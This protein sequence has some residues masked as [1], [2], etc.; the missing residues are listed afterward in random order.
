MSEAPLPDPLEDFLQHPPALP[1]DIRLREKLAERTAALLPRPKLRR[2]AIPAGI[3]A[4]VLLA[5]ASGFVGYRLGKT[6][7]AADF[8]GGVIEDSPVPRKEKDPDPPSA[9]PPGPRELEWSAFD[10]DNDRQRARLYFQ[11]GDLYLTQASDAESALRC[12]QQALRYSNDQELAI[13]DTDNWLVM[14]LK[15]DHQKEN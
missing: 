4:S 14:A 11:A 7:P 12:Y 3:A 1:A 13:A 5:L 9:T 8:C 2:W 6:E 15:R 10:A